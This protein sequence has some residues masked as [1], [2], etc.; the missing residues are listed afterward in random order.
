MPKTRKRQSNTGPRITRFRRDRNLR[1]MKAKIN[2]PY[3]QDI[4]GVGPGYFTINITKTILN[5]YSTLSYISL[6][7]I[8]LDSD[9]FMEQSGKFEIFKILLIGVTVFPNDTLDNVPTYVNFDWLSGINS[10]NAIIN[11]DRTKI[12]FNDAKEK[13]SFYFK[14]INIVLNS[15]STPINMA[16]WNL[17]NVATL[18]GSFYFYT[19]R[20]E[21]ILSCRIDVRV[22]FARPKA[23]L[24]SRG[25]ILKSVLHVCDT[26]G[27]DNPKEGDEGER[28]QTDGKTS[29]SCEQ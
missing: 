17:T 1:K 23:T 11:S 14:P 7:S 25:V 12:V 10:E 28:T 24:T 3:K 16:Q 18:P 26:S 19:P 6:S 2:K 15:S 4:T 22:L 8:I 13:R 5:Q 21:V 9:E 20:T 27:V 29:S